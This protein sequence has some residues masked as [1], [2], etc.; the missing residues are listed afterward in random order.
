MSDSLR[1]PSTLA[2]QAP[3]SMGFSRQEQWSALPFPSPGDLPDP[4]IEARS[5]TLLV[6][7][8]PSD[9]LER[10]SSCLKPGH[11]SRL[12]PVSPWVSSFGSEGGIHRC[13][14]TKDF[15]KDSWAPLPRYR[16]KSYTSKEYKSTLSCYYTNGI[17]EIYKVW[18]EKLCK[19][20]EFWAILS[21]N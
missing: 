13:N 3:L 15:W 14:W 21:R 16:L 19:V 9:H 5:P 20:Y 10:P 8:W 18:E 11:S 6:D 12:K 7:S 4:G 2:H 1:P 17:T